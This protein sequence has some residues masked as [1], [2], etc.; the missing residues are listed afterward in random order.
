VR[1]NI[2]ECVDFLPAEYASEL[3][4]A[5]ALECA[6]CHALVLDEDAAATESER[7]SVKLAVAVRA[8]ISGRHE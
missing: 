7:D 4:H 6:C 1:C 5:P 3:G 2:C 8:A